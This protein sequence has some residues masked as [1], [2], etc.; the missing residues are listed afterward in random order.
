M[1]VRCG[2][3]RRRVQRATA[4]PVESGR[5]RR[6]TVQRSAR[7]RP[8]P[9]MHRTV[10]GRRRPPVRSRRDRL[11][12][13]PKAAANVGACVLKAL[14]TAPVTSRI[15]ENPPG[16]E[17][18]M[19]QRDLHRDGGGDIGGW[20]AGERLLEHACDS[21]R[22]TECC[23]MSA[24]L[25]I[26]PARWPTSRHRPPAATCRFPAR[27]QDGRTMVRRGPLV[28]A[29]VEFGESPTRPTSVPKTL[30]CLDRRVV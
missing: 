24:S 25:T 11:K 26:R 20:G 12:R 13:Y 8:P 27:R 22:R 28:P 5:C 23:P 15:C 4:P 7:R 1:T 3:P 17:M 29:P 30:S 9:R 19:G 21:K 10:H 14:D 6:R 18:V 16:Q 2:R